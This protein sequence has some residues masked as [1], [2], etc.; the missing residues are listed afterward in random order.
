MV[1]LKNRLYSQNAKFKIAQKISFGFL[2]TYVTKM[3]SK[4]YEK[5]CN[6]L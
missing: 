3:A 5:S 6:F 4:N 2:I 1:Y